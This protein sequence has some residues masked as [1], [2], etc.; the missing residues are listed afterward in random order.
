MSLEITLTHH[1]GLGQ[2]KCL[3][4]TQANHV[5]STWSRKRPQGSGGKMVDFK[6]VETSQGIAYRGEYFLDQSVDQHNLGEF[7]INYFTR[8]SGQAKPADAGD[9]HYQ[10]SLAQ[11]SA[12]MKGRATF[13]LDVVRDLVRIEATTW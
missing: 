5:L 9:E 13:Y 2:Q 11:F 3:S 6:V 12:A 4:F 7:L 8:I 10:Q 1:A